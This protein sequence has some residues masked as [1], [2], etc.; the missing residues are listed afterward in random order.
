[1]LID[2][3]DALK[4]EIILR[5][6]VR[7]AG[8]VH[9][10]WLARQITDDTTKPSAEK[11]TACPARQANFRVQLCRLPWPG[12]KRRRTGAEHR[13]KTKNATAFRCSTLPHYWEWYP[14]N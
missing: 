2:F 4:W 3:A 10:Q 12:R 8:S 5:N 11:R 7:S 1:M 6:V 9:R 13:E 14:W